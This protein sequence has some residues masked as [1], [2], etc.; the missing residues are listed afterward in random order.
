MGFGIGC[1]NAVCSMLL[2]A[3]MLIVMGL[4]MAP[5]GLWVALHTRGDAVQFWKDN[6][7]D[8]GPVSDTLAHD[9]PCTVVPRCVH[10]RCQGHRSMN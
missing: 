9:L 4:F 2:T 7:F 6:V 5:F 1:Y 3:Q 10:D 8:I